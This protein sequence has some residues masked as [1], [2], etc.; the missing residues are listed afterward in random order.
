M[1]VFTRTA[2]YRNDGG[3]HH[4]FWT[5]IMHSQQEDDTN[6]ENTDEYLA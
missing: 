2:A 5:Y 6:W 3:R 4:I 1:R